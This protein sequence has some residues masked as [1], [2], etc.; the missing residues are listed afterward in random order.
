MKLMNVM[1]GVLE[2]VLRCLN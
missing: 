2:F 1:I